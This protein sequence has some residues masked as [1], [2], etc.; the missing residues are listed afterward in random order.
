MNKDS[1]EGWPE[2]EW[3]IS[4][5]S[6]DRYFELQGALVEFSRLFNGEKNERA[7]A[8]LGATYLATQ[9][10]HLLWNYLADDE[11]EVRRLLA[12]DQ[13]LGSFGGK[14]TMVY[15]LGLIGKMIR[16]DLRLVQK[17]RNRFA[18]DLRASFSEE[19]LRSWCLSLKWYT[20]SMN[21]KAPPDATVPEIFEVGV[22]QLAMHLSGI[23]GLARRQ[24]RKIPDWP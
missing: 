15:C 7:A 1:Q 8:I 4:G 16:D 10:E 14:I 22:N 13:P 20:I 2:E 17:I 21:M 9:L 18:H 11:K 19:P 23:V 24:Q 5:K 12:Y 6:L 3:Q